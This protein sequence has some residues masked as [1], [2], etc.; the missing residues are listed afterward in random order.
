[1][2]KQTMGTPSTALMHR[3][4]N[5]LYRLQS[6]QTPVVRPEL[7]SEYGMDCFPNG[8]NAVVAVISYTG[9]DMEDA[10]ILNKSAHER[11]FGHGTIYKSQIIDLGDI[12]GHKG[13]RGGSRSLHFGF[14]G[15]HGRPEDI[16]NIVGNDGLPEVGVQVKPKQVIAAYYD[17]I[18]HLT[19]Y[20]KY[21]GDEV[22]YIERVRLL[23][24]FSSW[25]PD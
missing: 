10:M 19:K 22:A 8:T 3:T 6:G 20:V 18:D 4:D 16:S 13:G 23:G 2:G 15:N 1:M 24:T 12:G 21:K 25:S 7:H 5:K 9:Y 14:A 17:E 11:G